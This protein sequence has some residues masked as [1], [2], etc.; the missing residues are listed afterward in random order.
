MTECE[1][2]CL[3]KEE[4]EVEA[5]SAI[6]KAA[7]CRLEFDTGLASCGDQLQ[8]WYFNPQLGTCSAFIY[9][10]CAGNQNRF[11][12][13]E[14]C[15]GFC[16][17]AGGGGA[18]APPQPG[19]DLNIPPP[20]PGLSQGGEEK[21]QPLPGEE[22][23]Q[24]DCSSS[25]E[26]CSYALTSCEYGVLRYQD[27][28]TRCEECYCNQPCHGFQCPLTTTCQVEPYTSRGETVF[29]A[30]CRDDTKPG[31]CPKVN[32]NEYANCEEEC[33]TDGDCSG[34]QKC[35]YNGCGKSCMQAAEDPY[36]V[37]YEDDSVAPVNPDAPIIEVV[38]TPVIVPE[39]DIATL[40]VRVRGN[41]QPDVYWRK[42]RTSINPLTGRFRI[43]PSG[44]L[45]IVGVRRE[46]EGSY[47]CFA[48]NGLGPP[49]SQTVVVAV[50]QA[51]DLPARILETEPDIVMSLNAPATLYC[52]AYGFPKPTVTWWKGT[53]MLPLTSD[54]V[55]QG[56]DF[57]LKLSS[58]RLSDLG[59]YTCQA[60]NG[61]GEAAS[62][63]VRL[64]VY[65]PV[66]PGPGE[67][68][69]TRYVVSPPSAPARAPQSTA[70]PGVYRP[71]RPEGW[72]FNRR[73]QTTRRPRVREISA[74]IALST[75]RFPLNSYVRIPCDVNSG[76]RPSISWLK[77]G[78]PL[79]RNARVRVLSNNTLAIDRAQP[80]DGVNYICRASNGYNEA[81]DRVDITVEDLQVQDSCVDN[82]YFANCKLIVK[83][84]YCGNKYY[85]KFC[86]R[87]CTLA[88]EAVTETKL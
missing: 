43:L 85:A 23:D 45:Q 30:V 62:F 27:D 59:P 53:S 69:F 20:E 28:R 86:C 36:M 72:D 37:E 9:S 42:G 17:A 41:P 2:I 51:R 87:S 26:R 33:T 25:E 31:I 82:P 24:V 63:N 14:V 6:S 65:G 8:R 21:Q 47:E 83:A 74:R 55:S 88:G 68:Q 19:R 15:M 67:Q 61:L 60:Y 5:P 29:R 11:K 12:T 10:G 54:R 52:L 48:D 16:E 75:T 78:A 77:D 50:D 46:D 80:E 70:R 35:C 73:P 4:P 13:F 34:Q 18:R 39:G 58:V 79:D 71:S 64:T 1:Q 7:I 57:T 32:R 76:L 66:N 44:A 22:L 56:D 49:V 84:R 38:N 40:G 3:T 81:E